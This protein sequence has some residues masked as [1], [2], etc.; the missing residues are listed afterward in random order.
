MNLEHHGK[1]TAVTFTPVYSFPLLDS[2]YNV[3]GTER[4]VYSDKISLVLTPEG[5]VVPVPEPGVLSG[6]ALFGLSALGL[7]KRRV[8]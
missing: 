6:L 1:N 3:L 8:L 4:R 2:N 5:T 7:R